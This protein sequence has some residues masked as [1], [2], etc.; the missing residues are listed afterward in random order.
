VAAWAVLLTVPPVRSRIRQLWRMTSARLW[1]AGVAV[2]CVTGAAWTLVFHV[3]DGNYATRHYTMTEALGYEFTAKLPWYLEQTVEG[4]GTS[5]QDTLPPPVILIAWAM[6]LGL[7]LIAAFAW[8]NQTQ[9]R[10]LAALIAFTLAIPVVIDVTTVNTL[11]FPSE[12]R[13]ILPIAAGIPLLAAF[14][15]GTTGGLQVAQQARIVRVMIFLLLPFQLYG[16]GYVMDRWQSG[17]GPSR[18]ADPLAGKWHPV[19]G[20]ALPLLMMT[21]GLIG[22]G[23]LAWR[24]SR[25]PAQA[26]RGQAAGGQAAARAAAEAA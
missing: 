15:V 20:S 23:L 12:G 4:F 1:A 5:Y 26:A 22:F 3:G 25:P 11:H 16:L 13:Y 6:A 17:L 18:S 14:T 7:L 8:G 9:R 24:A 2:S 10:R 21:L 19:T